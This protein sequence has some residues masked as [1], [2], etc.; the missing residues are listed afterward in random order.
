MAENKKILSEVGVGEVFKVAGI[1]FIKFYDDNENT[2]AVAK[3]LL[4]DSEFGGNNNFAE[5]K[6]LNRLQEEVLA[7]I[8]K[9]V[10]AKNIVEHEV[11][12]LS[13]DGSDKWEK[14]KTKI[15]LPTFDF[16]R[17]H[18]KIFD[19]HKVKSWWW[20]ATPETTTDHYTND[21]FVSCVS[22]YGGLNDING[23]YLS[24]GVRPFL[25]FV[26]SISVSCESEG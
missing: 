13:M 18:V 16:Y 21:S 11:D 10:G 14:V 3:N 25:F 9:E 23:S 12:L 2:V 7:K 15:S 4:F 5:S 26:S 1:E 22:P 17:K 19:K 8:E 6:I 20:L 24:I